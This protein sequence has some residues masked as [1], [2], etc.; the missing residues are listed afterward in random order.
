MNGHPISCGCKSH[1][2]SGEYMVEDVLKQHHIPYSTQYS[3]EDCKNVHPLRF[4]FAVEDNDDNVLFLIEYDG[5]QHYKPIDWFGG[6]EGF[7]QSQKRD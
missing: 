4:D 3:F 5:Q 2:S 7:E 1:V 6:Q